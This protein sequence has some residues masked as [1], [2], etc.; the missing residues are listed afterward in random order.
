MKY[1]VLV[2]DG[3]A[4]EPLKELGGKTPL[5]AARTPNMDQMAKE[6]LSGLVRTIPEGM[7]PG[8]DV[9]NL[10]VL[11]YNPRLNFSGR[12]PLEAA[13]L[14][15][16]LKGNEIAFRCNLVTVR[17]NTMIDY[18]S[19]HI[20]VDEAAEIMKTI[21]E[22]FSDDVVKF[23]VGKSYRHIAVVKAEKVAD[24]QKIKCTPPHDIMGQKI[25]SYLPSGARASVLI[26]YME[27][28]KPVLQNHPV[29]Q[30]RL[31]LKKEPATMLW[32]WGQG[33]KPDLQTFK[34]RFG[35][36][37]SVI[38]AVDLV[39]GIA[40]LTGLTIIN[41][42]GATG[43]YDTNYAGKAEYAL[44]SLKTRDF[45]FVHVEATDEAGHNGD[46]RAKIEAIENFDREI[47]G[48][49]L[50]YGRKHK[51]VRILVTPDHPTPVAK[52]THTSAPVP[53]V[54]CG[55]NIESNGLG[56]YN[57][58][59]AQAVGIRFASGEDMIKYFLKG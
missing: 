8:S 2:P 22:K 47:V 34:E 12:A 18:S 44:D 23:Y 24:F 15:I 16:I 39:N 29:N 17:D 59:S 27:R 50:D 36:E 35:L 26:D 51:D 13:N 3:V 28:A 57:E 25:D 19:G 53:F 56:S 37:G 5:E 41:V 30:L 45:I 31:G 58:L 46:A 32:F 52:R 38:S 20:S 7:A 10:S 1:L 11:G 43:Y 6:G 48:R 21:D 40:R 55:K 33:T 54:M 14:G 49:A 42:P 9:G 4:D